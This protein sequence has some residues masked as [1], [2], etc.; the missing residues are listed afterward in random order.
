MQDDFVMRIG[1]K[2]GSAVVLQYK[3]QALL[4]CEY[5]YRAFYN[6]VAAEE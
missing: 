3:G 4:Q 6:T 1:C 5:V 2:L